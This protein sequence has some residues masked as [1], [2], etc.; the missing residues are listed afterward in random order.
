MRHLPFIALIVYAL[1]GVGVCCDDF[2]QIV[3]RSGAAPIEEW[4]A[5]PA[6]IATHGFAYRWLGY[7]SFWL[8]DLLKIGWLA[9]AYGLA[10]RFGSLWFAPARAAFF[11]ALFLFYPSHDSTDFWYSN[12]YLTLTSAFLLY[13]FYLA[14][15]GRLAGAAAMSALGSFES[16]GSPPWA[17][18]LSLAF[19]LQ[20]KFRE[21]AA[22]LVP[23]LVYVAYYLTLTESYG[24][25]SKRLP[26]AW[27]IEALGRQFALQVLG[28]LDAVLGPSLLLKVWWS[29]ASLTLVS[30]AAGAAIWLL[31]LRQPRELAAPR[32]P[33]AM[34]VGVL[35]VVLGG[36]GIFALTGAYP[37]SA[38]GMGNRVTIYASFAVAFALAALP[39]PR[40]AH[41]ALAGV[42]VFAALGISDHWRAWRSVQD[43]TIA[44]IAANPALGPADPGSGTIF[45]TG[46]DYSRLGPIG[47]IA[48]FTEPWA[49]D[50]VFTLALGEKKTWQAVPLSARFRVTP[51][52]LLDTRSGITYAVGER[53]AVYQAETDTLV[54]VERRDLGAFVERLQPPPRHWIHLVELPWLRDLI[55]RWM[56]QLGYLFTDK[57]R[58]RP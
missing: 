17:I 38:F 57:S 32:I 27:N 11:A 22:L 48:F 50:A 10:Y 21:A 28:G 53:I 54:N 23:Q 44:A 2:A 45:V 6:L 3:F 13:G 55:L 29:I 51:G 37:Q 4:L 49:V 18:G 39:L 16:Y 40:L 25:G 7:G 33:A 42:L 47:H 58:L 15:R 20:R 56:P 43:R 35:A 24:V 8:Y 19:L 5:T 12:Q 34:W 46:R 26:S 30:A 52:G 31:I 1:H 36:F 41:G 9:L 14:E